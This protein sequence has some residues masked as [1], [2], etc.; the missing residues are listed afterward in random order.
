VSAS[1]RVVGTDQLDL[2]VNLMSSNLADIKFIYPDANGQGSFKGTVKGPVATPVLDGTVTLDGHKYRE[3]TIQHAEGGVKV[4]TAKQLATLRDVTEPFG[5]APPKGWRELGSQQPSWWSPV[6]EVTKQ[7]VTDLRM[8]PKRAGKKR[9]E[10]TGRPSLFEVELV[11]DG[12]EALLK[13]RPVTPDDALIT[14]LLA[15]ELFQAQVQSLARKPDLARVEKALRVLLDAG[16]VL[17]A[18]ALAQRI[19]LSASRADGF[20][21]VLRGPTCRNEFAS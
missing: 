15:S 18:T 9:R 13:P 20:S 3:W 14:A 1:G 10:D 8:P 16:G 12:G 5:A 7:P 11:P 6:S 17:P 4:D 21:A 2:T 19:S